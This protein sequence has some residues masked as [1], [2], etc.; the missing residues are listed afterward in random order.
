MNDICT[1]NVLQ[2]KIKHTP[3]N[4]IK[5]YIFG[6]ALVITV[7]WF[8]SIWLSK[9]IKNIFNQRIL[10]SSYRFLALWYIRAGSSN[11]IDTER[12]CIWPNCGFLP[13]QIDFSLTQEIHVPL[14]KVKR[15]TAMTNYGWKRYG[16]AVPIS[17]WRTHRISYT[18]RHIL[19][20]RMGY[21]ELGK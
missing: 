15:F 6:Q 18:E 1:V 10:S 2:K 8:L 9:E 16:V 7:Y 20:N 19:Y 12:A 3:G 5:I 4:F 13:N 21:L 17:D 14:Y 11:T